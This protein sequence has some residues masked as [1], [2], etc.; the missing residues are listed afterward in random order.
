MNFKNLLT[1]TFCFTLAIEAFAQNAATDNITLKGTTFDMENNQPLAYVS[2]GVFNKPQGSLSDS[3]GNFSF[4]ITKENLAD[5]LQISF[6][7]YS[8]K[9]I[10]VEDFIENNNKAIGLSIKFAELAEVVVTNKKK[11][12]EIIGR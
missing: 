4:Q 1:L 10:A 11:N 5:T 7:G 3:T 2:V 6:V 12:A 9:K 8:T